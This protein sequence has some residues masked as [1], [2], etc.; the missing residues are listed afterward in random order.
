MENARKSWLL[1][2]M[3]KKPYCKYP[4]VAQIKKSIFLSTQLCNTAPPSLHYYG[5]L[6]KKTLEGYDNILSKRKQ[7]GGNL[8][9]RREVLRGSQR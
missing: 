6:P 4:R 5:G 9:H 1:R 8:F 2:K 7:F 3:M